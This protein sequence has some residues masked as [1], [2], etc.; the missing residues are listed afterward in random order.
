MSQSVAT[1]DPWNL[2]YAEQRRYLRRN[3]WT[4][5][6]EGGLYMGGVQ[7]IGSEAVLPPLMADLGAPDWLIGMSPQLKMIGIMAMPM[8]V[9]H[10]TQ[11]LHRVMPYV[12]VCGFFQRLPFLLAALAIFFFA[13]DY[14]VIALTAVVLAPL[15]SGFCAG[16]GFPAWFEL[17][18]R[19]L[20]ERK[21]ASAWAY[22]FS[23]MSAIGIVAGYVV[24]WVLR[25][26]PAPNSYG[27]LMLITFVFFTLSYIIFLLIKESVPPQ[28]P[29]KERQSFWQSLRELP[30]IVKTDRP[31][32]NFLVAKLCSFGLFIFL[33]F[34]SIYA[35]QVTGEAKAFTG[36][37][38]TVAMIG[39][40]IGNSAIGLLGDRFG[41]RVP[42]IIGT[43]LLIATCG[44]VAFAEARFAFLLA[45]FLI[46]TSQWTVHA[47]MSTMASELA[48]VD[49]RQ[50]YVS[51]LTSVSLIGTLVVGPLAGFLLSA[52]TIYANLLV[53]TVILAVGLIFV[54]RVP[55]RRREPVAA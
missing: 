4:H 26:I 53:A 30:I 29:Q 14:P 36:Q 12:R 16:I 17:V 37:L 52:G 7:F 1:E 39:G 50:T 5:I 10:F 11:R 20:P 24:E 51:V 48:P 13:K 23:I 34:V 31:Y 6:V 47:G 18:C 35:L 8:I 25:E 40:V 22:R 19:T 49:R 21:R 15:I 55:N 46:G 27:V 54:L 32:R 38:L 9:Q 41:G 42:V 3:Y 45:F 2:H 33:P 28:A 43:I 44:I